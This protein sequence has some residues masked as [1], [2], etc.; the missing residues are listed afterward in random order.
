V[1]ASFQVNGEEIDK[2]LKEDIQ[3]ALN[4]TL[5]LDINN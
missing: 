4:K 5:S 2:N 3:E 1:R